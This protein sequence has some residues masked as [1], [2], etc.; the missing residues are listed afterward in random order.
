M[1]GC[2]IPDGVR[3]WLAE[4]ADDE[5]AP[6]LSR[7]SIPA[8][9]HQSRRLAL[10]PLLSQLPRCGGSIGPA[11]CDGHLRDDSA[12]VSDVWAGVC[13]NAAATPGADG[14]HVVPGRTVR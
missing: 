9:N 2:G 8:R 12:V 5:P 10:P 11:R 1:T 7:L 3:P 4:Y 13:A 6:Q 14:R